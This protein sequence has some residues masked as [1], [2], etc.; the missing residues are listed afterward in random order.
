MKKIIACPL[1]SFV[2][3][4]CSGLTNE[5]T[6]PIDTTIIGSDNPAPGTTGINNKSDS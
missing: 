3:M 4:A 1:I 5:K 2:L 6:K